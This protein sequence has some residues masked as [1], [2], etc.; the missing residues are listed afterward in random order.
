[1]RAR[2][3]RARHLE[4][5]GAQEARAVNENIIRVVRPDG[6]H[7]HALTHRHWH[8]AAAAAAASAAAAAAAAAAASLIAP[9]CGPVPPKAELGTYV[10]T[11]LKYQVVG[12]GRVALQQRK[13]SHSE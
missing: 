4:R 11:R 5:S 8:A 10:A 6:T 3:G 2:V 9:A 13:Y 7:A 1:V 12:R